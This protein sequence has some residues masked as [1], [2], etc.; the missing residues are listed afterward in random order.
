MNSWWNDWR[1]FWKN[2]WYVIALSLTAAFSY[3]FM[4]THQTIGIDDTPYAAY[5]EEGLAAIVGRWVLFLL[6]KVVHIAEFA[7]YLTDL[8]GVLILMAGVTVWCVLLKRIFNNRIPLY[9]YVLFSCLFLSNPLI[10]E[11]YTYYLHNGIAIGYLASGISLCCFWEGLTRTKGHR[12]TKRSVG[13]WI[14]SAVCLW[15]A[16]GCYESFMVVYLV[17][18]CIVLCSDRIAHKRGAGNAASKDTVL[19]AEPA[20]EGRMLTALAAGAIIAAAALILRSLMIAGVTAVFGLEA[21]K[22]EAVQRSL[23][24]MIGW[25]A[26]DGAAAQ[27][28]MILK[29]VILMYGVF[30]YAYYPIA[31]Y[32]LACVVSLAACLWRSV[33]HRDGWIVLLLAGSFVSSYLLVLVEGKATLYRAAQFLPLFSAWGLLLLIDLVQGMTGRKALSGKKNIDGKEIGESKLRADK[34]AGQLRTNQETPRLKG[35]VNLAAVLL[36]AVIVWNQ[37]TDMN[38]WFYVDYLKY[39]DAKETMNRIA[40]ELEKSFDTS[41][42]VIFTGTYQLPDSIL[43]GT[44]VPYNSEIFYKMSRLAGLLDPHI[45]EKFY[46]KQGVWIAQTPSLSVLEWGKFAFDSDEELVRFFAMHGHKLYAQQD[47]ALYPLAEQASLDLPSFPAQGSI[48][49]MGDYIIVHF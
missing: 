28:G 1:N 36:L 9:G 43:A 34:R 41:K 45:L 33:R 42:P 12:P 2:K 6:N 37:C 44:F 47:A 7:P 5:F 35:A 29:R 3:G 31:V 8:A 15:I 14:G 25:L 16:I 23:T 38:K 10:S 11:V 49:D 4:I 18:L 39:E 30:G 17:G 21:L 26:G 24:E 48:V 40:Y 13:V 19:Q 27:L 22:E 20:S 46:R 32:V